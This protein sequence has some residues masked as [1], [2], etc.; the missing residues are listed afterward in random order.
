MTAKKR[1][2]FT[3]VVDLSGDVVSKGYNP[4]G[5]YVLRY[6]RKSHIG[7]GTAKMFEEGDKVSLIITF[8]GLGEPNINHSYNDGGYELIRGIEEAV[9]VSHRHY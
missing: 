7:D 2:K 3:G 6:V 5:H 1:Y 4:S 9:V 8:L